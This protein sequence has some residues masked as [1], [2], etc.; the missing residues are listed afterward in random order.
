M[1]KSTLPETD[2]MDSRMARAVL[3]AAGYLAFRSEIDI[4]PTKPVTALDVALHGDSA[5]VSLACRLP[6]PEPADA[7]KPS[8]PAADLQQTL[9]QIEAALQEYLE[10]FFSPRPKALGESSSGPDRHE[11]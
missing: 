5:I 8:P 1:P 11:T 9:G 10:R 6:L 3:E 4:V 2:D 7:A